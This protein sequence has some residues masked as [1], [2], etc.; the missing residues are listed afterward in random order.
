MTSRIWLFSIAFVALA[1]FVPG[2]VLNDPYQAPRLAALAAICIPLLLRK[3]SRSSSLEL[4]AWT[5]LLAWCGACMFSR[6]LSYSLV[7]SYLAPFDGLASVAVY[8]ALMVGVARLGASVE[9]AAEAICWAS[10]P[11]SA[12][13]IAQRFVSDPF[14]VDALPSGHR[15]ISSQGSPVYLG[16]V[17]AI[18]AGTAIGLAFTERRRAAL[19]ALALAIPALWFTGTR[20]AILATMVAG[21]IVLPA[22]ARWAALAAAPLLLLHPRLQSLGSDL[23]RIETWKMALAMFRDH[24]FVG[25]GP[26]TYEMMSRVYITPAFIHAHGGNAFMVSQSGHNLLLHILATTGLLGLLGAVGLG[27][28][29]WGHVVNSEAPARR[30]LV[31]ASVAF[32]VAASLNPVPHAGV[33]VLALLFGCAS[34]CDKFED[35]FRGLDW[36]EPSREYAYAGMA[37]L[38]LVLASKIVVGDYFYAR[39]TFAQGRGDIVDAANYLQKAAKANPFEARHVLRRIDAAMALTPGMGQKDRITVARACL[40]WAREVAKEH[41][42]D[43]FAHEV[44]GRSIVVAHA[45]GLEADLREAMYEYR[46]AQRLAPTFPPLMLRR[47]FLA[48]KMG[49]RDEERAAMRDY[50][51]VQF[52]GGV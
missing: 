8:V 22:R 3:S 39:G 9:D 50:S 37:V 43:S 17:L 34:T 36:K 16:A 18:V 25:I 46:Q 51:Q 47:R 5:L 33:A 10:V 1:F 13:A 24:P 32:L 41:P 49:D 19:L 29:A 20:G 26:G 27:A 4:P 12:Y 45:F 6:D 42:N 2:F 38:S 28:A 44:L 40:G 11:V 52:I 15:V 35:I 30:I 7:G 23:G 21:F 31:S 48:Q 14:L